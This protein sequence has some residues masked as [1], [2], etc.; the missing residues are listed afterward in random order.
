MNIG[1][2][3][4]ADLE[5]DDDKDADYY[6]SEFFIL[7]EFPRSNTPASGEILDK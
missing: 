4:A 1:L 6:F 2:L 7:N 3:T 5:E